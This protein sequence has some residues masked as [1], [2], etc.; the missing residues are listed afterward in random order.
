VIMITEHGNVNTCFSFLLPC[1]SADLSA[2]RKCDGAPVDSGTGSEAG[3]RD[4]PSL[5]S[6]GAKKTKLHRPHMRP[7]QAIARIPPSLGLLY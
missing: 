7:V 2:T 3:W 6:S 4:V 5:S 1:R